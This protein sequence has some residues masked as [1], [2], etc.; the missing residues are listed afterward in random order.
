MASTAAIAHP[1]TASVPVQ[2]AGSQGL[3]EFRTALAVQYR[4]E[5]EVLGECVE[6]LSDLD[7]T[8]RARVLRY[9][10]DRFSNNR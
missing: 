4:D 6:A 9:L 7:A 8:T 3:Q 2:A 10:N 5:L 1:A